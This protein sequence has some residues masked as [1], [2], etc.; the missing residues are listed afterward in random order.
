ML[1]LF[2]AFLNTWAARAFFVVL[3]AAFALWGIGDVIRN[4][5]HDNALATVGDR[6]IEAPEFQD[7]FRRELAQ[8]TRM[9]GGKEPTPAIRK[10]V[11]GQSLDRMIIQAAIAEEV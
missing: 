10:T 6:R 4:T 2:R 7:T 3:V 5:G 9:M 11:A 8:V 1:A